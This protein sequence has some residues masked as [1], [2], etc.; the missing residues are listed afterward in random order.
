MQLDWWTL[1][2]QSINF[3]VVV[4][5]LNRFLYRPVRRVIAER[6]QLGQSALAD[7]HARAHK[8]DEARERYE[9]EREA[10]VQERQ[11][12]EARWHAQLVEEREAVLAAARSEA[13]ALVDDGRERLRQERAEALS[14]LQE[15]IVALAGELASRVLGGDGART[16]TDG[17]ALAAV[18]AHLGALSDDTL[19]E[20]REDCR[21]LDG[22][23]AAAGVTVASAAALDAD[24]Q[25]DWR[26]ALRRYLGDEVP[27]TFATEPALLGGVD[28]HFPHALLSFSLA[29]RL[30][31][32]VSQLKTDHGPG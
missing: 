22:E 18:A 8:A 29:T 24:E 32:A 12:E 19:D 17:G 13:A 27:V 26:A 15:E 7:A 28:V 6:E 21:T 1:L 5:L 14:T 23:D 3:L 4:W 25:A 16:L 9:R 10:L 31:E 2:L 11:A 30:R 20:L